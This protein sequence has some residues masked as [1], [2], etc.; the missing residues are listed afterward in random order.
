MAALQQ[1]RG[2]LSVLF[3]HNRPATFTYLFSSYLGDWMMWKDVLTG[4]IRF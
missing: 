3:E 2:L 4:K 1:L